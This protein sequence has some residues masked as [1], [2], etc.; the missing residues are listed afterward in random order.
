MPPPDHSFTLNAPFLV[1]RLL[2]L[3]ARRAEAIDNSA[4]MA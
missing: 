2:V 1:F 3:T 4:K